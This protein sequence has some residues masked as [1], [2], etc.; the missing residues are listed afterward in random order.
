MSSADRWQF[1]MAIDRGYA[2]VLCALPHEH[3][4]HADLVDYST[5]ARRMRVEQLA[6]EAVRRLQ[7]PAK[8]GDEFAFT[9]GRATR[10]GWSDRRESRA[11]S[12]TCSGR[13]ALSS[14]EN[15]DRSGCPPPT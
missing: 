8:P 11:V 13:L 2:T 12:R 1:R 3:A 7:P 4:R 15:V 5:M 10:G 9:F 14:P 6:R